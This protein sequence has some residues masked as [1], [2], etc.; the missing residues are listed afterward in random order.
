[1][2]LYKVFSQIAGRIVGEVSTITTNADVGGASNGHSYK[3]Y[4]KGESGI[5]QGFWVGKT[6]VE[7][8]ISLTAS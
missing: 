6:S 5:E 4:L 2:Q 3:F 7:G 1:M 8:E